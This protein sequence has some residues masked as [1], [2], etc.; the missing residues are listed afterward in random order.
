MSKQIISRAAAALALTLTATTA[1]AGEP[2]SID[3]TKTVG[4][5][6]LETQGLATNIGSVH[7]QGGYA[8]PGAVQ[9][10]KV[11]ANDERVKQAAA[12]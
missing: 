6:T 7:R 5:L 2:A 12:F 9:W 4:A 3:N 11:P 1:F 8:L 10:L